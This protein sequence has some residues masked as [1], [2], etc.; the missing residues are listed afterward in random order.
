MKPRWPGTYGNGESK[1]V[2]PELVGR[3]Y[4]LRHYSAEEHRDIQSLINDWWRS[5]TAPA[6]ISDD[7]PCVA[8][9]TPGSASTSNPTASGRLS[10][11]LTAYRVAPTPTRSYSG[12]PI[13]IKERIND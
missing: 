3:T 9:T 2:K 10:R 8:I 1:A 12:L 7:A 4:F 5:L 13:K 11:L 6:A